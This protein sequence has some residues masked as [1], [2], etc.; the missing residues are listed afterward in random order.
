[1]QSKGVSI[2]LQAYNAGNWGPVYRERGED[3]SFVAGEFI[4]LC[5]TQFTSPTPKQMQVC[6]TFSRSAG[7]DKFTSVPPAQRAKQ[8]QPYC[9]LAVGGNMGL[10]HA[11][12]QS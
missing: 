2:S 6:A 4:S 10:N 3:Y 9:L 7:A 8:L 1:M 5:S 12:V 11:S